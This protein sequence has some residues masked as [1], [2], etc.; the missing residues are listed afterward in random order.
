MW[1]NTLSI[2][3]PAKALSTPRLIGSSTGGHS[4]DPVAVDD[5]GKVV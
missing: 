2:V 4:A 3:M 1:T 5:S